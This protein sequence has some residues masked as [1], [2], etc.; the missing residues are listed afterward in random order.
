MRGFYIKGLTLKLSLKEVD[1]YLEFS[2][3]K[4]EGNLYYRAILAIYKV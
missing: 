2:M 1:Y 4:K 3:R